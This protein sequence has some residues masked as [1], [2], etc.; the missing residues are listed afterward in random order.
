MTT[1][2]FDPAEHTVS[3]IVEHV[4]ANPDDRDR[5]LE[6]EQ[7]G[8]ARKGVLGLGESGGPMDYLGRLVASDTDQ[9]GR[10]IDDGRDYLGRAV[11]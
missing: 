7:D 2:E 6:A 3:E 1:E 4:D 5:V 9:L 8:K 11:G 10:S